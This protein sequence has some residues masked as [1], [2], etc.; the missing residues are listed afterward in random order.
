MVKQEIG[1]YKFYESYM[2]FS[3]ILIVSWGE[4]HLYL[5]VILDLP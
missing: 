3:V 2:G 4:M 1:I 5:Y